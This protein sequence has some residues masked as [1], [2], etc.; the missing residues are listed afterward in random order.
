MPMDGDERTANYANSR[1]IYH[2]SS[3]IFSI[4]AWNDFICIYLTIYVSLFLLEAGCE[5]KIYFY[6]FFIFLHFSK[7]FFLPNIHLPITACIPQ[8]VKGSL[9]P[10]PSKKVLYCSIMGTN[11]F[12]YLKVICSIFISIPLNYM[13]V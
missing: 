3:S 4:M 8:K 12:Q 10:L 13:Q 5:Q 9:C 11:C 2:I 1:V 7:V 6:S